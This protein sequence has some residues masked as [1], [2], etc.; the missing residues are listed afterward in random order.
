[1]QMRRNLLLMPCADKELGSL[2]ST[3]ANMKHE[4]RKSCEYDPSDASKMPCISEESWRGEARL[5]ALILYQT[6][7]A[8]APDLSGDCSKLNQTPFEKS[9]Q[10]LRSKL[11]IRALNIIICVSFA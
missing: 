10:T 1:V 5:T 7:G 6:H 4:L 11:T 3:C 9:P 8:G 2:V